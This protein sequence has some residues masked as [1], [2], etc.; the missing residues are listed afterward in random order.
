M[1]ELLREFVSIH[2]TVQDERYEPR[3]QE[4]VML[5]ELS[6]TSDTMA[7]S[8]TLAG[9]AAE[10]EQSFVKVIQ[11]LQAIELRFRSR[12]QGDV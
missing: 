2:K 10:T 9:K 12:G 3:Q 6:S 7:S 4:Q 11:T 5:M 1:L 8:G